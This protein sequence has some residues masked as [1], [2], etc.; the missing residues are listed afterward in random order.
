MC[1]AGRIGEGQLCGDF[2]SF[3]WLTN[4]G[5]QHYF[6]QLMLVLELVGNGNFHLY[7][8]VEFIRRQEE[9]ETDGGDP[10]FTGWYGIVGRVWVHLLETL[11]GEN[12]IESYR[13]SHPRLQQFS[14]QETSRHSRP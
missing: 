11:N 7:R 10:S 12:H 14:P 2:R 13:I 8:L 5:L 3:G 4:Y 6:G 1:R 9:I